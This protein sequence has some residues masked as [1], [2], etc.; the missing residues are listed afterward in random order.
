MEIEEAQ[1][2]LVSSV[3]PSKSLIEPW[4]W[5]SLTSMVCFATSDYIVSLFGDIGGVKML[6]YYSVGPLLA[7]CIYF[8]GQQL[9]YFSKGQRNL[10]LVENS[11][12]D[13]RMV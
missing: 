11:R 9:G 1:E 6:M 5:L 4:V 10:F 7:G 3:S 13:W 12:V 2:Q 8:P